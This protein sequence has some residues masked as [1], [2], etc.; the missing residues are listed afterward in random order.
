[1]E[2]ATNISITSLWCCAELCPEVLPNIGTGVQDQKS[3]VLPSKAVGRA[4]SWPEPK[5]D[6]EQLMAEMSF[7]KIPGSRINLFGA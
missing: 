4:A 3:D 1:M 2:V 5:T 6:K 7:T